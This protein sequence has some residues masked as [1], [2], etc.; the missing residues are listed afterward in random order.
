[1]KTSK[2]YIGVHLCMD[3]LKWSENIQIVNEAIYVG[4]WE[5]GRGAFVFYAVRV[6]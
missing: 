4:R 6:Y 2:T 1:M 3:F 5:R